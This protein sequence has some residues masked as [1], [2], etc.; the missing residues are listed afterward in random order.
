MLYE[1]I[2]YFERVPGVWC[3]GDFTLE[4][5]HGGY[6]ITGRSAAVLNPG[7]VRIGTAEIYRPVEQ[8]DEVIEALAIGQDWELV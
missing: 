1:V 5:G 4:T 3:H 2:T 8:L 7:G 6:V